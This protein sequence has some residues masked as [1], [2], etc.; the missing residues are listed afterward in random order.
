M[1]EGFIKLDSSNLSR[2]DVDMVTRF[3][4]NNLQ[5]FSAEIKKK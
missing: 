5:Y 3:Y 2:V 4:V 1:D